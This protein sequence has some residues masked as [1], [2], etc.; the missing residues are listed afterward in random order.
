MSSPSA[1]LK[2][3]AT[4]KAKE[5]LSLFLESNTLL[6]LPR[7]ARPRLSILLV[8]Y[9]RAELT[10]TC[11][12]SIEPR[13]V[14]A[15]AEVVLVDNASRD[16]TGILLDRLHGATVIRNRGNLGFPVAVNQAAAAARGEFLLLLNNDTEVLGDSFGAAMRFLESHADVG[17][18]GGRIILLDGTL[19]EAGCTF[20][21][22]GH[23]FQYGRGDSPTAAEYQFQRDVDYCSAAF[24]MTR[25]ELFAQMG[26]L[27][28]AFSPGYFE[29]GDYCIRLWRAGRHVVYL[30]E[31]AILHYE[32]AS[33][34]SGNEPRA[35]YHRNLPYFTQKHADWLAC[36]PPF[37]T[38]RLAMRDSQDDRFKVLYLPSCN[39]ISGAEKDLSDLTE[40]VRRL[41]GL[42]CFVTVYP[43]DVEE[44][45]SSREIP[46]LPPEVEVL[47]GGSL[48][49]LPG[50]LAER[51]EYYDGLL[52]NDAGMVERIKQ[53]VE[54]AKHAA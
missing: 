23:S 52:T 3:I 20:W 26:G 40:A 43:L 15:G 24:L 16:E 10:L 32:N 51:R 30:P 45:V 29:D 39:T 34:V 25:R 11:L 5:Q 54:R 1:D 4:A 8:L 28:V 42:N 27:D 17:A 50:F 21:R 14:E 36:Q 18:V 48:A 38:P 41:Q 6:N 19:Q 2:G 35:L 9:N 33:A 7:P 12:R 44:T 22:E 46:N 13:L 37:G 47:P 49:S 53:C 31:V